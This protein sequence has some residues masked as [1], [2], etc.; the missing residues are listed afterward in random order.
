[1]RLSRRRVLLSAAAALAAPAVLR[2]QAPLRLTILHTNDVHSRHEPINRF[3]SACRPEEQAPGTCFGGSARLAAALAA[4]RAAAE[5]DGRTV[6]VLDAGDQFIGSLFYTH[7]RGL[8]ELEVMNAIGYDAMAVGNHEFDNGPA[9]FGRF[10]RGARF[11]ILSAN[12]DVSAEPELADRIAPFTVLERGGAKIGI[13]GLTTEDTPRISSPGQR[14]RFLPDGDALAAASRSARDRGASAVIALTHVGLRRDI[15]LARVVPGLSAIVGG[16]SHTL[17]SNTAQGAFAR[18]PLPEPGAS[19]FA[20]PIVQAGANNRYYGRLDL[21]LDSS[22]RVL[23]ARGD[24]KELGF[25]DP[26]DPAVEAIV[27]RL[28]EPL[29]ALRARVIG[30][31]TEA[32]SN[33]LCRRTEC[34]IGNLVAE[35]MLEAARPAGAEVALQNGGGIRAGLPAG[36]VTWGDLLTVLPFSNT[37]ATLK[38]RGADL[39]AALENGLS[40]VEQGAG[41]F[42]QVAGLRF[43][44]RAN[45]PAGSRLVAVS[46]RQPDGTYAPLDDDRLYGVVTNNFL[47]QGGDAYTVLRDRAIDP[48]DGGPNLEEVVAAFFS[49]HTPLGPLLDGRIAEVP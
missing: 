22:G 39:R 34:A 18:Y 36:A 44:W 5:R 42:P 21:D 48:Y 23:D 28:A 32:F 45:A 38:L 19:G 20:V 47:R 46:V 1:M 49:R 35:A 3:A 12:I 24:A 25:A 9:V 8:A 30:T 43:T 37:L 29:V 41:R 4:E 6:L 40:A 14:V 27:A 31:T 11:A 33:A 10:V 2:A 15:A 26:R 17:L 13:V 7:W 16:H